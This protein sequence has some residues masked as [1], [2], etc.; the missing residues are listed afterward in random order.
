MA[1]R[2]RARGDGMYNWTTT[3][4][5]TAYDAATGKQKK[6]PKKKAVP[7]SYNVANAVHTENTPAG[8]GTV[9]NPTTYANE[10][11]QDMLWA[12]SGSLAASM[13]STYGLAEAAGSPG[14]LID[15]YYRQHY[16]LGPMSATGQLAQQYLD[17]MAK[18]LGILGGK[19]TTNIDMVNF[20]EQLLQQATAGHGGQL[21]PM[22]MIQ[23]IL[24]SLS[25]AGMPKEGQLPSI[26]DAIATDPNPT[27]AINDLVG[28][29]EGALQ[30]TMP[31]DSLDA[32]LNYVLR[33]GMSFAS[34]MRRMSGDQRAGAE[35][36]GRSL[37]N[38][39]MQALGSGYGLQ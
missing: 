4:E 1:L 31:A 24:Q 17:P 13:G 39:L 26:F 16:G 30:G 36:S 23:T 29:L 35:A 20:G 7:D 8:Q 28:I 15:E 11:N 6:P 12:P 25:K 34:D 5:A 32:F 33:I 19:P 9:T 21:S 38:H 10:V 14:A 27:N 18:S 2:Q 3:P 22:A 37:A